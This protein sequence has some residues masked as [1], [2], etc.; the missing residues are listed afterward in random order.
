MKRIY[1]VLAV[2][3]VMATM[4]A[5]TAASAFAKEPPVEITICSPA[6]PA[7]EGPHNGAQILT[8]RGDEVG[9]PNCPPHE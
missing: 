2:V 9:S 8:P 4:L 5:V 3:A 6:P 1:L 7:P